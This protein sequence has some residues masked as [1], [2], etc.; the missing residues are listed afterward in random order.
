MA[1][2]HEYHPLL[3]GAE[4]QGSRDGET[5]VDVPGRAETIWAD[6]PDGPLLARRL[7][8]DGFAETILIAITGYG[9]EEDRRR[10]LDSGFDHHLTKPVSPSMLR[11]LLSGPA[12]AERAAG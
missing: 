7:R 1:V 12:A 4:F 5:A 8:A 9:R 10:A 6:A 2:E 3:P 11:D